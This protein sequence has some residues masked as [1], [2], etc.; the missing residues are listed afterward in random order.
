MYG[1]IQVTQRMRNRFQK[2]LSIA[3]QADISSCFFKQRYAKL[4]FQ[5]GNGMTQIGLGNMQKP[6]SLSIMLQPGNRFEVS[7]MIQIHR[8]VSLSFDLRKV[9]HI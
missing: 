8:S 9:Y 6:G 7:K 4:C 2:Q 5:L 3:C 1:R